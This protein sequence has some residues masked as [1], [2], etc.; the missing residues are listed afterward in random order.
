MTS[1]RTHWAAAALAMLLLTACKPDG[2]KS[3][4]RGKDFMQKRD[5]QSALIEFRNAIKAMPKDAEAHY[6]TAMA[7]L[8]TGD[9][10]GGLLYLRRAAEIDPKHAPSQTKLAEMMAMSG[11]ADVVREA[12]RRAKLLTGAGSTDADVLAVLSLAELRLG[13]EAEATKRLEDLVEKS[14]EAV[15]AAVV[16]AQV[17]LAKG[18]VA[19]A[20][21]ILKNATQAGGGKL[22]E[23]WLALSRFYQAQKKPAETEAALRKVLELDPNN[24]MALSDLGSLQ[25]ATNRKQDA[26][27]TFR[28]L[29]EHPSRRYRGAHALFLFQ[30]GQREEGVKELEQLYADNRSS[31]T[32]RSQLVAA[33]LQTNRTDKA[34]AVLDDAIKRSPK[35]V[36]LLLQRGGLHAQAGRVVALETDMLKALELN[37]KSP[38]AHYLM[39]RVY[40][41]RGDEAN[42]ERELREALKLQPALLAARV[43]LSQR[44]LG[45]KEEKEALEILEAAPAEQ[46]GA[47]QWVL[48]RNWIALAKGDVETVRKGIQAAYA[49]GVRTPDFLFQDAVLA[50]RD[51]KLAPARELLREALKKAPEDTRYLQALAETFLLENPQ[52]GMAQAAAEVEKH[53][54]QYPKSALMQ[55]FRGTW[56]VAA[57][58][59]AEGRAAFEAAKALQPESKAIQFGLIRI[60]LGTGNLDGARKEIGEVLAKDPKDPGAHLLKGM[61]EEQTGD[62]QKAMDS[63]RQVLEREPS[64]ALALNNLA[65]RLAADPAKLDDALKMAQKAKEADPNNPAIDDTLGWIEYRKGLYWSSVRRLESATK[66]PRTATPVRLFHLAMAYQKA[67]DGKKAKLAYERGVQAT[68]AMKMTQPP[69]EAAMAKQVLGIA[70]AAATAGQ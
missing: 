56:L 59:P 8:A 20:E 38:E 16:L 53:A 39:S 4:E 62:R 9:T 17:R 48:Q 49:A 12:E 51:R 22:W 13:K 36:E 43:D 23:A 37:P 69:P 34:L 35:E 55:Q 60:D 33:Y 14:P 50:V 52:G 41:S 57:G 21:T 10:N 58:R 66:D 68:T 64:N 6:Q 7:L 61:L 46:K 28:R 67:G 26:E 44:M 29:S 27:A 31:P 5:Y 18:D 2:P 65:Y 24:E 1:I 19:G 63:Y 54:E 42:Q 40:R 11:S 70:G 30:T 47:P 32:V 15:K 45:L 3:L 25:L